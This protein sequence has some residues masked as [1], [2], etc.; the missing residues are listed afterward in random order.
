MEKWERMRSYYQS[1]R[2]SRL[3]VETV[4]IDLLLA[5]TTLNVFLN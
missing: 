5:L 1:A 2:S 4:A 3:G